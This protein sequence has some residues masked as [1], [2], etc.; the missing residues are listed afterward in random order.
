MG[1]P[2]TYN[3]NLY[4]KVKGNFN[5]VRTLEKQTFSE[6]ELFAQK[7]I[8]VYILYAYYSGP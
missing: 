5:I 6:R 1:I 7:F 3:C 8:Y 2:I 4:I